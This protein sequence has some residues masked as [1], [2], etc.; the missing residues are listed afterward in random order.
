MISSAM[1]HLKAA[2]VP[3]ASE[4]LIS[5]ER[6]SVIYSVIYLVICSAG[7]QGEAGVQA[8]VR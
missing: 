3:E 1:L 4:V 5:A 7:V 8:R 2:E 6:I